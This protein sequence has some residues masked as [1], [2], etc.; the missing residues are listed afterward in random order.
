MQTF[1][2]IFYMAF[3]VWL[4][5]TATRKINK[6]NE[7]WGAGP[8]VQAFSLMFIW[9]LI[10]FVILIL[11]FIIFPDPE[12]P[13]TT[14]TE[15]KTV[16]QPTPIKNE[17]TSSNKIPLSEKRYVRLLD[18]KYFDKIPSD[19]EWIKE[20]SINCTNYEKAKNEI[21]K[22]KVFNANKEYINGIKFVDLEVYIGDIST[23][24]G[25]RSAD[26][27]LKRSDSDLI[28]IQNNIKYTEKIYEEASDFSIG[29]C[30]RLT[31]EVRGAASFYEKSEV[32]FP[33]FQ[34]EIAS[35]Q[36]CEVK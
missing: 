19:L 4:Y 30:A 33:H 12:N 32:C 11:G 15:I 23:E 13:K 21:Q 29:E 6:I 2:F 5:M 31:G 20:V 26:L 1:I 3:V 25:G 7:R 17:T 10:G 35:L 28:L 16:E 8:G 34:V 18:P 14:N 27:K 36:K 9:V 24:K 22:S